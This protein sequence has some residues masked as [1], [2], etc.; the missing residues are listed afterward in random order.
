MTKKLE[1][2]ATLAE[3]Q[4]IKASLQQGHLLNEEELRRLKIQIIPGP[5]RFFLGILGIVAAGLSTECFVQHCV[6]EGFGFA[7]LGLFLILFAIFGVRRTLGEIL[8]SMSDADGLELLGHILEGVAHAV[9]ALF[10]GV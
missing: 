3:K 5:W 1:R 10:D 6:P 8:N 4:G 7:V 9:G 2:I